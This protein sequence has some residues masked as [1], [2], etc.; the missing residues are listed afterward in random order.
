MNRKLDRTR[1]ERRGKERQNAREK[2]EDSD[3]LKPYD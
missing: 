1:Q 2:D 3:I